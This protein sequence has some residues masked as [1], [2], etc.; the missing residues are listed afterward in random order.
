MHNSRNNTISVIT[1]IFGGSIVWYSFPEYQGREWMMFSMG[2]SLSVMLLT[3][4]LEAV[5]Y[6]RE[7]VKQ[8]KDQEKKM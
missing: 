8:R 6:L 2:T 7:L 3:A 1:G 4:T 5:G